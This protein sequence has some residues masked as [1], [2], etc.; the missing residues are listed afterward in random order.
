MKSQFDIPAR[1]SHSLKL[2]RIQGRS[3]SQKKLETT[4]GNS[5]PLNSVKP[6]VIVKDLSYYG[7][8][9]EK[10][11][12]SNPNSFP[13]LVVSRKE[14]HTNSSEYSA[15]EPAEKKPDSYLY[16]ISREKHQSSQT[17]VTHDRTPLYT[18]IINHKWIKTEQTQLTEAPSPFTCSTPN[19][20]QQLSARSP[21]IS[22]LMFKPIL[23]KSHSSS[24]LHTEPILTERSMKKDPAFQCKNCLKIGAKIFTLFCSHTFCEDCLKKQLKNNIVLKILPL[25]CPRATCR[26]EIYREDLERLLDSF[27]L[28][29]FKKVC[30]EKKNFPNE[31]K[32]FY[33][34]T[35]GCPKIFDGIDS[36][37]SVEMQCNKCKQKVCITCG[38]KAHPNLTCKT[39]R[40]E[41]EKSYLFTSNHKLY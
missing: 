7:L 1:F 14:I 17:K 3:S 10:Q 22:N 13:S 20:S 25:V 35:S 29:R 28:K 19:N 24:A 15:T 8:R 39:Y 11:A 36:D 6:R 41:V 37:A 38:S 23:S 26:K 21:S 4:N 18:E 30:I 40:N 27:E 31:R 9:K 32:K 16:K 2:H 5:K 33:C 12:T 34:P